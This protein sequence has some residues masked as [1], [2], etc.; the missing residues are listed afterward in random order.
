MFLVLVELLLLADEMRHK[1][2]VPVVVFLK[3]EAGV[4]LES[5]AAEIGHHLHQVRL[6]VI[7]H[8]REVARLFKVVALHAPFLFQFLP[9]DFPFVDGLVA[10]SALRLF[11]RAFLILFLFLFHFF[12]FLGFFVWFLFRCFL[13]LRRLFFPHFL[14]VIGGVY[15]VGR[16][17]FLVGVGVLQQFFHHLQ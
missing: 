11:L 17:Q 1:A 15:L 13:L 2:D 10:P 5:L 4:Q 6:A 16:E 9:V 3:G 8:L 12:L 14:L 7:E